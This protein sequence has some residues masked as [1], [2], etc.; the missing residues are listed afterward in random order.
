MSF[1]LA[2]VLF[3]LTFARGLQQPHLAFEDI[4]FFYIF[5]IQ[6]RFREIGHLYVFYFC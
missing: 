1:G 2:V 6:K 4:K 5:L 3:L